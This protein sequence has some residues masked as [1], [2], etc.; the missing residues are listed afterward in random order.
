MKDAVLATLARIVLGVC[1]PLFLLLSNLHLVATPTYIQR[2]YSSPGFPFASEYDDAGRLALAEA[3]LYY[4]RSGE[5]A[6]YLTSLQVRGRAVYNAREVR[7]LIDAKR[8]MQVAFW[9]HGACGVLI[10]AAAVLLWRHRELW[11]GALRTISLGCLLLFMLL[12]G[13]GFLAFVNFNLFFTTFH[14]LFFAGDTWLFPRSDTLIQLFPLPFWVDATFIIALL[15]LAESLTVAVI[16]Y[17]LS[18]RLS[19]LQ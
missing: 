17:A 9:V 18:R 5:G 6:D 16:A 3:T 19:R 8:V 2:E 4:M 14:R 13:I 1:T 11:P 7:H 12:L 15:T 10:L